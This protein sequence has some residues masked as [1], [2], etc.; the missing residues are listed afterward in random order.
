MKL[1]S[2]KWVSS[3]RCLHIAEYQPNSDSSKW[4][5][6]SE[7]TKH[8]LEE[9]IQQNSFKHIR[10]NHT[11]IVE[12]SL[13]NW[14]LL[15]CFLI[16]TFTSFAA[17]TNDNV[18]LGSQQSYSSSWIWSLRKKNKK[19]FSWSNKV[20][21]ADYFHISTHILILLLLI[22]LDTIFNKHGLKQDDTISLLQMTQMR[23]S[24]D[25]ASIWQLLLFLSSSSSLLVKQ[26]RMLALEPPYLQLNKWTN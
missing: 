12:L 22:I 24:S 10:Y 7:S 14:I 6:I 3:S 19:S 17:R 20:F 4:T 1:Y 13:G 15:V 9:T 26:C 21:Q 23:L 2:S 11:M 25:L 18:V 16:S 8:V 5:T